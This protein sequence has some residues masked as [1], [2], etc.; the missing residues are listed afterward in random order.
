MRASTRSSSKQPMFLSQRS[1]L[2]RS[3]ISFSS[4]SRLLSWDDMSDPHVPCSLVQMSRF[5]NAVHLLGEIVERNIFGQKFPG[6]PA[7]IQHHNP[8]SHVVDVKDVVIDE[9]SGFTC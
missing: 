1:S 3:I 9:N 4:F 5:G 2:P 6:N 8:V 7:A